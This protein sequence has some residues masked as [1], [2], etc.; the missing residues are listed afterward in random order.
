MNNQLFLCCFLFWAFAY[1]QENKKNITGKV[2]FE[3]D[4]MSDVHIINKNSNIGTNTNDFG[5]FEIS[6]TI[7][8]TLVFSHINIKAK[9]I[10][11]TKEIFVQEIFIVDVE[12]KTY[13]LDEITLSTAKSIFFVD[14]EIM[15]P[16]RVNAK[17]LHLPYANSIAKKDYS[18]V[19]FRSGGVVS[20]DNLMNALNGNNRRRKQLEK[21]TLEDKRLAKIRKYFTDDFFITDLNIKQESI[22]P[23]L[24][25]CF[26][27][28]IIYYFNKNDNLKVT[29]ILMQESKT[30]PQDKTEV[31][32]IKKD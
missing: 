24:N 12:D 9:T 8:D 23:F 7:G 1:S 3:G 4:V 19:K 18:V 26:K 14:P 2:F 20:L 32:L 17:T 16:T 27:K 5:L 31:S 22:N 29:T 10:A 15:P 11:I 21:I 6:T 30:F 28:N 13:V 25:Y